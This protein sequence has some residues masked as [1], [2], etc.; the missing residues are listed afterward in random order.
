MS[1]SINV[2]GDCPSDDNELP[3]I[4]TD[5]KQKTIH[6]NTKKI[7]HKKNSNPF[8]LLLSDSDSD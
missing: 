1:S 2:W 8:S 6:N 3:P 5:W 7:N 4:P